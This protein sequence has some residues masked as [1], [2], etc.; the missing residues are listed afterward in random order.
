MRVLKFMW[1]KIAWY[2]STV[3]LWWALL[4]DRDRSPDEV[5]RRGG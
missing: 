1:R 3:S 4:R 5:E 2:A